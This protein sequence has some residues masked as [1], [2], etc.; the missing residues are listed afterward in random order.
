[1][2]VSFKLLIGEVSQ[3]GMQYVEG[4]DM[5][6]AKEN[7]LFEDK[8]IIVCHKQ[9]GIATQTSRLGEVDMVNALRNYLK[10]PYIG[11]VHR[12]DQPV[13]GIL[14]FAK[15]KGAAAKLSVQNA[16]QIMS[17]KYYAVVI[18]LEMKEVGREYILIDYLLKNGKENISRV[19]EKGTPGAKRAE[20]SY[21][22]VKTVQSEEGVRTA[23]I[24][25]KLITGRHHQI[26]VQM[27]NAGLPLLGD[28]KYGCEIS[29]RL[30][31]KLQIKNVALCAY[32]LEFFHPVT[33]KK[34][35][36]EIEP[37]SAAFQ[38]FCD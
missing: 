28:N 27:S 19:V 3:T 13:E 8:E 26:R 31:R 9:A 1:M 10:S 22:I 23:L 18:P 7:I 35:V 6:L 36:F 34:M 15:T 5:N 32:R 24:E 12:L 16:E 17:K 2:I 29:E 33:G 38:T 30:S 11:V 20:L 25:V 4:I 14:V 37:S 21:K